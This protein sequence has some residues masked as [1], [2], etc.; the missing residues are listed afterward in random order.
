[1]C[2]ERS[3]GKISRRRFHNGASD[4]VGDSAAAAMKRDVKDHPYLRKLRSPDFFGGAE[5]FFL[6]V[7]ANSSAAA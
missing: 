7:E 3:D 4:E 1:M 6:P 2:S 5:S